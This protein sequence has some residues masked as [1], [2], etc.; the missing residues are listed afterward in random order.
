MQPHFNAICDGGV[1]E[2]SYGQPRLGFFRAK[3]SVSVR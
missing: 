3:F 1:A 2:L